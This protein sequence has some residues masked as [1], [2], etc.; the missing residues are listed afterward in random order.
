MIKR[1]DF[2]G[3]VG[4]DVFSIVTKYVSLVCYWCMVGMCGVCSLVVCEGCGVFLF[5]VC[6]CLLSG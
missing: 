1:L 4:V 3:Y 5:F 6:I 2:I